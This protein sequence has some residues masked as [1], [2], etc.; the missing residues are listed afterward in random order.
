V[1]TDDGEYDLSVTTAA[2]VPA[3]GSGKRF[4]APWKL[5]ALIDG[6]PMLERT[7]R[8]L[9]AANIETIILVV[10]PAV[11]LTGVAALDDPRVRTVV[12]PDPERGMFSSIQIG[13]A[14]APGDAGCV[15]VHPADMPFIRSATVDAV[16]RRCVES[17]QIVAAAFDGK[18]GH[19]VAMPS[20]VARQV[21]AAGPGTTLSMLFD[22]APEGRAILPVDD[23]GVL[24]DVDRPSDLL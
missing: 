18:R 5:M 24:R 19:P 2:V 8:T 4:G 15:L 1:G 12:N 21:I 14:A 6:M 7:L 11:T 17:G 10:P 23:P 3:A 16:S 9:L 13:V 22:A 20:T